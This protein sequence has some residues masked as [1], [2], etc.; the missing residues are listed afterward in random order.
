M[1]T[2]ESLLEILFLHQAIQ[3]NFHIWKLG[4][5]KSEDIEIT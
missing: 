3:E 5:F 2:A 4:A 1:N